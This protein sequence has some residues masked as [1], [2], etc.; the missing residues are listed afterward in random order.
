VIEA[1]A[2]LRD[3]SVRYLIAGR[4]ED[5]EFLRRVAARFGVA[6]RVHL[7]GAVSDAVLVDL[8]RRCAAF[9]LPSGKEGFGIVFL[10]AMFFGAPVIAAREK[11]AVDVVSHDRSGLLVAY[12]DTAAL[13]E[14]IERVLEDGAL[15]ARL[16]AQGLATVTGEGAFTF[17]AY[18]VRLGQVLGLPLPGGRR[19]GR[20]A[21]AG[22]APEMAARSGAPGM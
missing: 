21:P 1:L 14:A 16:R 15:R 12:G 19:T 18:V 7:L 11:G 8:Y 4:G 17:P 5:Q 10:E 3:S 13:R 6:G 20:E 2:M 22:M 9:V